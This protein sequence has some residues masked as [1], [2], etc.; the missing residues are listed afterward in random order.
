L[1]GRFTTSEGPSWSKLYGRFTT[2]EGPSWSRLYGRF[3]TLSLNFSNT[4][5]LGSR[6]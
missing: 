2:S 6:L 5:V 4:L 1:Y 3:T